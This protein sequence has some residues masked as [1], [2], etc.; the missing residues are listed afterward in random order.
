MIIPILIIIVV[1]TKDNKDFLHVLQIRQIK[2][3]IRNPFQLIVDENSEKE[4]NYNCPIWP[5]NG[6]L[7][8]KTLKSVLDPINL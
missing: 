5:R 8:S 2:P 6:F 1:V 7:V 4:A 3:L